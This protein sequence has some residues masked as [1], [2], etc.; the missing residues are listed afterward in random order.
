R[1]KRDWS[2]D[3]CSSDLQNFGDT[4][5]HGTPGGVDGNVRAGRNLIGTADSGE[6]VNL[7]PARF[8]VKL[9]DVPALTFLQRGIDINLDEG[10]TRS[11]ERRVGNGE[12]AQ[13]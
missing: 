10:I 5:L 7:A 9:L 13:R 8:T 1:S 3:V 12:R 11:E 4:G 2:S 6:V